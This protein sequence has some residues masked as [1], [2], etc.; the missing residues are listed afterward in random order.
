MQVYLDNNATTMVDPEVLEAILPF[1]TG[2]YGNPSSIHSFG[3]SVG[4]EIQKARERVAGF[5]GADHDYEIVFTG[6]GTESDNLA[7]SGT[8]AYYTNKKHIITSRVEHPAVVALC[9]KLERDGYRIT[10]VPVD[11]NGTLDLEYLM[12][13]VDDDTAIVSIMYANNETGVI[14]PVEKIGAFLRERGVPFHVDAVQA[15]G[16]VPIDVNRINCDLLSI[17]GHK[18]HAPKGVGVLYVR[19]GTRIRPILYGGHQEKGRRPGTENVPGIVGI[20]KAAEMAAAH[21]S[22]PGEMKKM[23]SMRDRLEKTVLGMFKNSMLNGSAENRVPNTTNIGFEFIEGEAILLYLDQAG[24]SASSGSA[25][26]SGSLE[27]SHVLRAMGVPFTSA[28]GSI[29]FSLSR[30]TT[31]EEI[32]YVISVIPGIVNRLLEIS[33]YWDSAKQE[34]APVNLQAKT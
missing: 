31:G 33:P 16:K 34:P 18:F 24:V 25:C 23:A 6:T 27:P 13:S 20:G 28:H 4:S 14:F 21:L 3:G 29:R 1:F 17:S 2:R 9:N 22:R 5:L 12:D 7:I 32:D 15:A 10:H 19:R 11:R 8:I 30:F 26:S